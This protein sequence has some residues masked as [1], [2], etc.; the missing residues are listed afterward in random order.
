MLQT[1][2]G[3][4]VA[5]E[6][7]GRF[8]YALILDRI[9]LFGGAWSFVFAF[10]SEMP[11]DREQVLARDIRGWNAFVDFIWAKRENRITRVAR[12]V[13][14][15]LF[16]GPGYLK[17]SNAFPQKATMWSIQ[18][19][20]TGGVMRKSELTPEERT[21]PM[22]ECIDD[23]VMVKRVLEDWTPE[24]EYVRQGSL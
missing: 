14:T 4:L 24:S 7:A 12:G 3:D 9:A 11:L 19:M 20:R 6:A 17:G 21:Y 13:D 15:A 22:N 23:V 16:R 5:I 10:H 2:P 1:R 8:F 18:D